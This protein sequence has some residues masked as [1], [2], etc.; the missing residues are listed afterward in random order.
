MSLGV[1][2]GAACSA[3]LLEAGKSTGAAFS[4]G[5]LYP[6]AFVLSKQETWPVSQN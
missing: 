1:S 6:K 5:T 4:L 2:V 3:L